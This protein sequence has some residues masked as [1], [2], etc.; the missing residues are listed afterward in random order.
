MAPTAILDESEIFDIYN[1]GNISFDEI[2]HTHFFKIG[3]KE[4]RTSAATACSDNKMQYQRPSIRRRS[5]LQIFKESPMMADGKSLNDTNKKTSICSSIKSDSEISLDSE[6]EEWTWQICHSSN[7][8][9]LSYLKTKVK[10]GRPGVETKLILKEPWERGELFKNGSEPTKAWF[11][12]VRRGLKL[13]KITF[14][15]C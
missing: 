6:K 14:L 13:S 4:L 8:L 9:F 5:T 1:P 2:Q 12:R 3:D 11:A 7:Y 15:I 10:S